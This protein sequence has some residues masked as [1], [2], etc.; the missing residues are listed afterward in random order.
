M[1]RGGCANKA[2]SSIR[3]FSQSSEVPGIFT[4]QHHR[5]AQPGGAGASARPPRPVM[6]GHGPR[7]GDQRRDQVRFGVTTQDGLPDLHCSVMAEDGEGAIWIAYITGAVS[8]IQDGKVTS[9]S[10][11]DGL[12]AEGSCWLTTDIKGRLWFAKGGHVGVFR[13]SRFQTLL[14]V[15]E[16]VVSVGKARAGGVWICAGPR[17]LNYNERGAPA[18]RGH[19]PASREGIAPKI[20]LEDR[21]GAVWI[22][23]AASRL[24]R[25]DGAEVEL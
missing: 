6:A 16:K 7:P 5:C 1:S 14:S 19:L 15:D 18:E 24:F 13:D 10:A 22:G 8:R 25:F 11:S 3:G 20:L 23:T 17:L 4:R 12:P 2:S 9:F 21:T